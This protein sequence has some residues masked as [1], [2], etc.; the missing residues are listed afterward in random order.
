[1]CLANEVAGGSGGEPTATAT[2]TAMAEPIGI[3]LTGWK[4]SLV[5]WR[6]GLRLRPSYRASGKRR[7][8]L[9]QVL[10]TRSWRLLLVVLTGELV[11]YGYY[12]P[13]N[14][15]SI[16]ASPS[17]AV[18]QHASATPPATSCISSLLLYN[19][20]T[21]KS[22]CQKPKS[23]LEPDVITRNVLSLSNA[24]ALYSHF[25]NHMLPHFPFFVTTNSFAHTRSHKPVLFLAILAAAS[26]CI[27]DADIRAKL[28]DDMYAALSRTIFPG[29]KS[30]ELVQAIIITGT[31]FHAPA[32]AGHS[33]IWMLTVQATV[34]AIDLKFAASEDLDERRA[35]L[36]C[37]ANSTLTSVILRR[38]VLLRYGRRIQES[39]ELVTNTGTDSDYIVTSYVTLIRYMEEVYGN[40]GV[41][42]GDYIPAPSAQVVSWVLEAFTQR[43]AALRKKINKTIKPSPVKE[44]MEIAHLGMA[45]QVF[46]IVFDIPGGIMSVQ[47]KLL[48]AAH[49]TLDHFLKCS[50]ETLKS[51]PFIVFGRTANA[52][53]ILLRLASTLV[54][55]RNGSSS[56]TTAPELHSEGRLEFESR[57]E[58][59][60]IMYYLTKLIERLRSLLGPSSTS[61]EGGGGGNRTLATTLALFEGMKVYYNKNLA[62]PP[63][64]PPPPPPP[65]PP[66]SH[67]EEGEALAAA[68][69]LCGTPTA[70]PQYN[71]A[72]IYQQQQYPLAEMDLSPE[73]IESFFYGVEGQFMPS[74]IGGGGGGGVGMSVWPPGPPW[75]AEGVGI[76]GVGEYGWA[77]A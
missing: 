10:H 53:S 22:T 49:E 50:A 17:A 37:Y 55:E 69:I 51:S 59:L 36:A 56:S 9:A 18:P 72:H 57:L 14:T 27:G 67:P 40:S 77:G 54:G 35:L 71:I 41:I 32:T 33:R 20:E 52:C 39:L 12:K 64:S 8:I 73:E 70:Y 76:E 23:V 13:P 29:D 68:S 25:L 47:V 1:M 38:P 16:P 21:L 28:L 6:L 43:I 26:A 15:A 58:Q 74:V 66:P 60:K 4:R 65:P 62:P 30:L 42:D 31:W 34:I 7:V 3:K 75:G 46:A 44:S 45:V 48:Q 19:T 11:D 24:T 61:G 5:S 63:P 2:A